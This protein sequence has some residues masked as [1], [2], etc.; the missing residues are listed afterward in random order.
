[1]KP[2]VSKINSI[3]L[4]LSK[5]EALKP[6]NCIPAVK[7]GGG[8][9]MLWGCFGVRGTGKLH[10]V[11]GIMMKEDYPQILQLHVEASTQLN[12]LEWPFQML[13]A[14]PVFVGVTTSLIQLLTVFIRGLKKASS[15]LGGALGAVFEMSATSEHP[16]PP[17]I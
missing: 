5:G 9:I 11:V 7:H 10:K 2:R 13:P 14:L 16:P 1:K 12:F 15:V 17:P 8:S 6:K 3:E 4:R